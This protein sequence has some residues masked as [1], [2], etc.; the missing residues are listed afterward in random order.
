LRQQAGMVYKN[1]TNAKRIFLER[2]EK[3]AA[4]MTTDPLEEM[5]ITA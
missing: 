3:E 5:F 2:K 1:R 4:E